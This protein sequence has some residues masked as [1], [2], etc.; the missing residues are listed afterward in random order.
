L[1]TVDGWPAIAPH[2]ADVVIAARVAAGA[3]APL[4]ATATAATPIAQLSRRAQPRAHTH[5]PIPDPFLARVAD[6]GDAP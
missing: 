5:D 6:V 4:A 3:G 1:C 2:G